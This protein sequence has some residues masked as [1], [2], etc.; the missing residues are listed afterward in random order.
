GVSAL[1]LPV[2]L[3]LGGVPPLPLFIAWQL[4]AFA[5]IGLLFGNLNALAMEPLEAVAGLGAAFAGS[6]TTL[7]SLPIG[8]TIGGLYAGGVAPL[9]AGFALCGACALA[10]MTITERAVPWTRE[11]SVAP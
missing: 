4:L 3:L 7:L 1:F 2:V 10:T 9:V 8:T 11:E 6:A 5:C